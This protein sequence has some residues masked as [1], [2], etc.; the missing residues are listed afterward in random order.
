[1]YTSEEQAAIVAHV[2]RG[3]GLFVVG[4]H[5]N[6][7]GTT[8]VL[9]P[10][11]ASFGLTLGYD[12]TYR[13]RDGGFTV[14]EPRDAIDPVF[15]HVPQLDF[16]T[17]CTVRGGPFALPLIHDSRLLA[18]AADYSTRNFFP[19]DRFALTSTFGEF[20]QAAAVD[21]GRGRVVVFTD[22]T[23]FSNFSLHMD[24]YTGFLL[25]AMEYLRRENPLPG[26]KPIAAAIGGLL[27]A[28]GLALGASGGRC[29]VGLALVGALLGWGAAV[30]VTGAYHRAAYPVPAPRRDIPYVYFDTSTSLARI[31]AQPSMSD[32]L[33]PRGAF[34]TFF[35]W[36]QRIGLVPTLVS[37][38]TPLVAGRPY[39]VL[40]PVRGPDPSRDRIVDYVRSQG[41]SLVL[42]GDP[43]RDREALGA[44]CALFG[45]SLATAQSGSIVLS[46]GEVTRTEISPAQTIF[47]SV[48]RAG[49]GR[50]V[51]VSDSVAFSDL[52]LGGGFAVPSIVQ[53]RLYDLEFWLF[54]TLL[55]SPP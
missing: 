37:E 28:I 49:A 10:V 15:Q 47:T 48:A 17:S 43:L 32:P 13:L 31:A 45:F 42:L 54:G 5:T 34:G 36:T 18:H 53:R 29:A 8:S 11:L 12:A 1:P 41:G 26:W 14:Y 9:N 51:V 30:A 25:G 23:C 50:V 44:Y 2:R 7:F 20:L 40:N 38:R 19:A 27:A 4:D 16:L 21:A 24:G 3:G 55:A 52:A 46:G 35:T 33:G 22:S 6:V 39:V